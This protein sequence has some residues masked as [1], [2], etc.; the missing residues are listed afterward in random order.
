MESILTLQPD[1]SMPV[2]DGLTSTRHI[3]EFES[4]NSLPRVRI[5]ALTCFGTE[6]HR[7]DAALSGVDIFL[8]KP[9]RMAGLKPILDLDPDARDVS[10]GS[11]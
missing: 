4:E 1:I 6:E 3:R 5:V 8:T 7:R 9:I 11:G 2:M 10:D